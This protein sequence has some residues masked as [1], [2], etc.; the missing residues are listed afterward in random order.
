MTKIKICGLKREKDIEFANELMPNFIGF[1][2]YKKSKR[3][4]EPEKALRLKEKLDKNIKAV[5]V[6]VNE[7]ETVIMNIVRSGTIDLIQLHGDEEE[8]YI[9]SL[10]RKTDLPIIKAFS[11]SSADDIEKA[12]NTSADFILLDNGKGGSGESFD[13]LLCKDIKKLFFLAGGVSVENAVRAIEECK[14]FALDANSR[15]EIDGKKDYNLMKDF[16]KTVRTYER[17]KGDEK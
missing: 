4:I 9:K 5:G 12:K 3:Y 10:K 17:G 15:L 1:I 6:F 2:F 11:I 13:W 14:P 8:E 7:S 16:I